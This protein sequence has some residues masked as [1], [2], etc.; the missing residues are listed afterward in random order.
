[1][2]LGHLAPLRRDTAETAAEDLTIRGPQPCRLQPQQTTL[3]QSQL[4]SIEKV[5]EILWAIFHYDRSPSEHV[6]T[7]WRAV[8]AARVQDM[9][10]MIDGAERRPETV[11][12]RQ[13]CRCQ[14]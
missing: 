12:N 7:A 14:T 6:L 13:D 11:C 8:N 10:E 3:R 1:M 9:A 2:T 4:E 5:E